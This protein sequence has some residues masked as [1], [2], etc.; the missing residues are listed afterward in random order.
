[1][2]NVFLRGAVAGA[3]AGLLTSTAAYGWLE[4]VLSRAIELEGPAVGEPVV[5]R[6]AQQLLGMPVGFVLAGVALGLLFAVAYRVLPSRRPVWERSLGLA[7]G[8]FVALALIPQL[9]YPA[10]PPGVGDP[11]TIGV[12]TSSFL[13]AVALGVVVVSGAYAALRALHARGVAAPARQAGVAAAAVGLVAVGYVLLPDSGDAVQ[14]PAALVY[15]FRVRSLGLL[16]LLYALLGAVFA[17]L[18]LR[19][20]RPAVPERPARLPV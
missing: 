11:A 18:T 13:L 16:A 20:E 19:G 8:G 6:Q 5:S 4:P 9:R 15:D 12:R 10:N 3:A 14:A 1:M 7:A 17:A 2:R